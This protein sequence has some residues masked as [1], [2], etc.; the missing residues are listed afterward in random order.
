MTTEE[1]M[2]MTFEK[3]GNEFGYDDVTTRY[4]RFTDF[5]MR[6]SRSR[7][8]IRFDV[9]DYVDLMP[10]TAIEGLARC[11]FSKIRGD[12]DTEYPEEVMEC[13]TSKGFL[14][15]NQPRYID[16]ARGSGW[17]RGRESTSRNRT[18]D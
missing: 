16:A 12:N 18:G 1:R 7:T 5:K 15:G 9:S 2:R 6:W 3:V 14:D 17:A 8:W 13:L 11:I 10:E 4:A